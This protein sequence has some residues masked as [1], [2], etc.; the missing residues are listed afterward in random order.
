MMAMRRSGEC[1]NEK[2]GLTRDTKLVGGFMVVVV[3]RWSTFF[4]QPA[5][6]AENETW[7][8]VD[9]SERISSLAGKAL[10]GGAFN[11]EWE[12]GIHFAD[13]RGVCLGCDNVWLGCVVGELPVI[14]GFVNPVPDDSCR[15]KIRLTGPGG[16]D[17]WGRLWRC[18]GF[19]VSGHYTPLRG[20][21]KWCA[22]H[23]PSRH[24]G[25]LAAHR[26]VDWL[27]SQVIPGWDSVIIFR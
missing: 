17:A 15:I 4:G 2:K 14:T 11:A 21:S 5:Q 24:A 27:A 26:G 1:P 13:R 19:K 6:D 9:D 23:N 25:L 18:V 7:C 20:W 12:M 16:R 22:V 10:G 3:E 8:D